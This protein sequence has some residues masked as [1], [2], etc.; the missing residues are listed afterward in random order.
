MREARQSEAARGLLA[1]GKILIVTYVL[2]AMFE[3][4][5]N[6]TFADGAGRKD[7]ALEQGRVVRFPVAVML[8][9]VDS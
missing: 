5:P 2:R 9:P 4:K 7:L 6:P 1:G 3:G 8:D